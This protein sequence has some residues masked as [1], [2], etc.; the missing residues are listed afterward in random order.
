M[1]I[2]THAHLNFP[3]FEND[4]ESIIKQAQENGVEKIICASSNVTDSAK[5]IE[6][7]TKYPGVVYAAVGIHPQKTD[8]ENQNSVPVQIQELEELAKQKGLV[9]IGEC[10]LDYSPAPSEEKER[11]KEEQ[12]FLFRHQIEL[13]LKL[14]LPLII[15]SRKA[16]ADTFNILKEYFHLSNKLKGVFHC[17][18]A[19][20]SEIRQVEEIGFY[21]GVDGNL[22]YDLGLQN[23]VKQIP[24][25][26][27]MLET[28]APFLAPEPHR[29]LRNTPSSVKIIAEFLGQL[30]DCSLAEVCQKTT[31][32][33]QKIFPKTR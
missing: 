15:H 25:E 31:E 2:D 4:L 22:T 14:S 18:A 26:Q 27:I 8:P 29:G 20:K 33:A 7:A 24:L 1:L 5:A 3:D 28:D 23:V 13:A 12:I 11:T 17:Y 30:K 19:G 32:N 21:F 10:G 9:A 16:F 6:I